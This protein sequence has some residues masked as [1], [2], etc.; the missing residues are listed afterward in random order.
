MKKGVFFFGLI[1]IL[2]GLIFASPEDTR[3][4]IDDIP[5]DEF[6]DSVSEHYNS[7][8][9]QLGENLGD[10]LDIASYGVMMIGF[11]LIVLSIAR[12]RERGAGLLY[13]AGDKQNI[14]PHLLLTNLVHPSPSSSH[15][16]HHSGHPHQYSDQSLA[17]AIRATSASI[18]NFELPF[19]SPIDSNPDHTGHGNQA[20]RVKKVRVEKVNQE[21]GGN[22]GESVRSDDFTKPVS[23]IH[24]K[25]ENGLK[26]PNCHQEF[27]LKGTIKEVI[28][29]RCGKRFETED[30]T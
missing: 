26:C 24:G 20:V 4:F 29:P 22:A 8:H 13:Q 17:Q 18:D 15:S 7:T 25:N 28:C 16:P 14:S 3:N 11:L 19:L 6:R 5:Q 23:G 30:L 9:D 12:K 27:S 1:F 2:L 10:N 21:T